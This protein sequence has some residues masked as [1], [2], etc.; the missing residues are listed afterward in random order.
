LGKP[1]AVLMSLC[2]TCKAL[3]IDPVAY[4]RGVLD[5]VS[6][7]PRSR[8]AELLPDRWQSPRRA[9]EASATN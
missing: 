5:R 6:S 2:P 3:V 7:R 8:I 9:A 4:L 1:A